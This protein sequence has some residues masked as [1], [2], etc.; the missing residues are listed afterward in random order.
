VETAITRA[1]RRS[2]SNS[3]QIV[4]D[5]EEFD[6]SDFQVNAKTESIEKKKIEQKRKKARKAERQRRTKGRKHH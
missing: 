3:G 4:A 5:Q 2:I 1:A 6:A